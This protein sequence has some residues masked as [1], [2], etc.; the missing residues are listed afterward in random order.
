MKPLLIASLSLLLCQTNLYPQSAQQDAEWAAELIENIAEQSELELDYSFLIDNLIKLRHNPININSATREE[1]EQIPFLSDMQ[2]EALLFQRYQSKEFFSIYELQVVEGLD[3]RALEYLEP[4]ITFDIAT[5]EV[6]RSFRPRADLFARSQFQ[7]QKRQ[8]YEKGEDGN[9]YYLGDRFKHYLRLE[10]EATRQLEM[11][12]ISEKDQGEQMF[13]GDIKTMDYISGYLAWKPEKFVKQVIAGQYRMSGG[14]GLVLQTG[15]SPVKSSDA[16]SIRNRQA[17]YRPAL[18]AAEAGGL[19][20]LMLAMGGENYSITPFIS[21]KKI[22]GRLD[23]LENNDIVIRSLKSDGYHRTLTELSQRKNT[24]ETV[25][26]VQGHYTYK[27]LVLETGY[28][29]YNLEYPLQTDTSLYK[30]NYFQGS[31]NSNF[32]LSAEGTIKNVHMFSEL[33]FNGS[34]APAIWIGAQ[35][36]VKGIMDLALAFRRIGMD[37]RAPLGAALTEAAQ[38]AGESG[39]YAGF[40]V[41]LP[42]SLSLSSYLDYYRHKWLRYRVDAPS[43]GYDYLA[44]LTHKP[45][46][47]W[48]NTLRYRHRDKPL[49]I[50]T[51]EPGAPVGAQIHNQFRI[52]SRYNADEHWT[53]TFRADLQKVK[54]AD[55]AKSPDGFYIAQDIK[56]SGTANKWNVTARYALFDTEEYDTR[57]YA[58]EP[59]VTYSF[60]TPSYYG[61]GSRFIIMGKW[62]LIP[63]LDFWIRY[64]SWQY[65]DRDTIGSGQA[66]IMGN[67]S[68][69]LK[70]QLRKRF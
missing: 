24:L 8:G 52:Q 11:G 53:F 57:V 38:P 54:Q 66:M 22:D 30:R 48:E 41:P 13:S 56:Y 68:S 58:Y 62:T 20:G 64:A 55:G 5:Q 10:I 1:L 21:L 7:L 59:D 65:S 4:L 67:V 43:D 49:N 6:K 23:T 3:R 40:E 51:E 47:K 14:Q 9:T 63:R 42:A 2:I 17:R 32:W 15:M 25:Y 34:A 27:K 16:V 46:R 70:F 37:Y 19:S 39:F 60:S 44:S 28:L 31:S 45:N 12:F 36:S 18:S 50:S 26:G 61:K 69:E 35:H 33:A 29:S